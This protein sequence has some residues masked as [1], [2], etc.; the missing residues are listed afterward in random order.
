MIT[1]TRNIYHLLFL[2]LFLFINASSESF[3]RDQ[4]GCLTCHQY[5]GLVRVDKSAGLKI[6]H[7]DE[8]L[9]SRSPHGKLTCKKCHL[10]LHQVPH[11]G[12]NKVECFNGC[13]QGDNDR[14][15]VNDYN[16]KHLHDQEQ[17]FISA[18]NDGTAC[19][20]C[21]PLYPHSHDN[22]VRALLNM[23]TGF[24]FCET[25]HIK[26]DSFENLTYDWINSRQ[27]RFKG[28]PFGT[29]FNPKADKAMSHKNFISRLAIFSST[30]NRKRSLINSHDARKAS[31]FMTKQGKLT[32]DERKKELNYFHR[33]VAK[34]EISVACDECH[35]A[36]GILDF[37]SLGFDENKSRNLSSINIKGLV[38][39]YKTFYF[40][41]MLSE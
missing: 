36:T 26:R 3:A 27:V 21:H 11:T 32:A 9:Y 8:T 2:L 10:D 6:L 40:P 19:R 15:M 37:K 12:H 39:K 17:F 4:E 34:K 7:I 18:L 1:M 28:E 14:L 20:S 29:R 13:H 31:V 23:H 35:S 30:N 5:P 33:E 38:T 25:C 16:L 41:E 22:L 24:M